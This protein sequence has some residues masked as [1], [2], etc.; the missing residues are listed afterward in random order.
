MRIAQHNTH[1]DSG[2]VRAHAETN[3]IGP[4]V[5]ISHRRHI[6]KRTATTTR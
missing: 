2:R 1:D 5:I 3:M 4:R 6:S